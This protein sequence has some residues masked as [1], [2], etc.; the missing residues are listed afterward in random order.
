MFENSDG[1]TNTWRP[2]GRTQTTLRANGVDI[3]KSVA[4]WDSPGVLRIELE[5]QFGGKITQVYRLAN[6]EALSIGETIEHR[7]LAEA[8]HRDY[9]YGRD[10]NSGAGSRTAAASQDPAFRPVIEHPAFAPGAGPTVLVD[11]AHSGLNAARHYETF[12]DVFG[13]DGYV[14]KSL[15]S[16]I[17]PE[18]LRAANVLVV[19]NSRTAFTA[20]EV[21]AVRTWVADGGAL[22]MIVDHPPYVM[23]TSGLAAGFGIHLRNAGAH[24]PNRDDNWLFFRRA[25]GTL[26]DHPITR[27]I[28]E[29][30]TFSGASFSIDAGGEPLLVFG[31]HACS[32]ANAYDVNPLP[33]KG[34]LQGAVL[35]VGRGRV[36]VFAEAGMFSVQRGFGMQLP[37]AKQNVSFLLN[38]MHWL[39]PRQ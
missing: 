13:R 35:S 2:D 33:L 10:P 23:P 5:P 16:A 36:A 15:T 19:V 6:A 25:D 30:V 31:P 9:S 4:R 12:S 39:T 24:D 28:D 32:F 7:L 1:L 26:K 11:R 20:I 18:S 34:Q 21:E 3:V 14:V 27:G 22:L 17:T 38:V 29:V 8:F 37:F